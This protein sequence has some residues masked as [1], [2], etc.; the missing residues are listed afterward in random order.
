MMLDLLKYLGRNVMTAREWHLVRRPRAQASPQD[1]ALVDAEVAAPGPGQVVVRN[2]HLSVDPYMR[3]RMDD[4]PSYLP[5]FPIGAP[6]DGGAVGVVVES[7]ADG[8]V[9]GR[10]VEHFA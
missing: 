5:P 4:A 9:A 2:T 10:T 1:F 3:G 7:R 8:I 6:L